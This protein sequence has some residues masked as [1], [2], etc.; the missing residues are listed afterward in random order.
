MTGGKLKNDLEKVQ[1]VFREIFLDDTLVITEK[2]S[3]LDIDEW[4]SLAQI[5]ILAAVESVFNIRFTADE[6]SSISDVG[7]LLRAI[8]SR[9]K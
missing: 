9:D 6:M 3:P 1:E 5:N 4:D 2:T 8:S 7:T